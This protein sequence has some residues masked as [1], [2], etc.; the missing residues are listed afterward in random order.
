MGSC[1]FREVKVIFRSVKNIDRY[2]ECPEPAHVYFFLRKK[3]K[4]FRNDPN[5]GRDS[6]RLDIW[7]DATVES[8][9]DSPS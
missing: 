5:L 4:L 6:A 7:T 1:I 3:A 8:S 2:N 9:R